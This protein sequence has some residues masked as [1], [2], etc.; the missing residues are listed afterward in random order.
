MQMIINPGSGPVD[1]ATEEN[2]IENMKHYVTDTGQ[3]DLEF[4]RFP[5][6]DYG[7][8]R[9]AFILFKK[10]STRYHEIQMPGLQ[11]SRV[12]FVGS[13]DQDIWDFPRLYVDGSSWVWMYS[14]L[15]DDRDWEN[16]A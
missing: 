7:E 14:I 1:N 13:D 3:T 11:L 16:P 6:L 9:F 10:D 12:R 4:V 15:D 5:K 2:A 8:G